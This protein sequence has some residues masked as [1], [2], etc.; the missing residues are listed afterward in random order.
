M[1]HLYQSHILQHFLLLGQLKNE[2]EKL[3]LNIILHSFV[4]VTLMLLLYTFG[5]TQLVP[6]LEKISWTM[7]AKLT[8]PFPSTIPSKRLFNLHTPPA[9]NCQNLFE[10]I[11]E[12]CK[13]HRSYDKNTDDQR[14]VSTEKKIKTT[15]IIHHRS[16][17][18]AKKNAIR[19]LTQHYY[20]RTTLLLFL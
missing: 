5:N 8:I 16:N 10:F 14:K 3:L 1:Y 12:G 18:K 20:Q 19:F 4:C 2:T 6:R 13:G 7:T 17:L 15:L 11:K 9:Q